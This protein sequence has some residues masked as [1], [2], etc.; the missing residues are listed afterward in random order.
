MLFIDRL[1]I[2]LMSKR[3]ILKTLILVVCLCLWDSQAIAAENPQAVV[4]NGMDQI[5]QILTR[6]PQDTR[7]RR[8][9]IQAVVDGYFDFEAIARLAVG[10][11]WKSELP[12]KQQ[13]FTLEFSKLL[14]NTYVGDIQKYAKQELTYSHRTIDQGYVV[15]ETLVKDQGGPVSLHYYLHIKDGDWKVYDISIDGMSLVA[16]YRSQFH[17]ILANSS[18]DHLSMTLR[19]KIVQICGSDRC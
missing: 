2:G 12:E 16:N 9:Q 8:E 5:L 18:F 7:D 6:Y 14:F 11:R 4:Q 1:Q 10:P 19:Q 15:V 17:S 3:F 13:E